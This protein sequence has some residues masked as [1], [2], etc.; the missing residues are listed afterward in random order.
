MSST[1][2]NMILL[3]CVNDCIIFSPSMESI[4]HLVKPENFKLTDEGNVNKFLGIEITK[5]DSFELL[6]PFLIDRLLA[7]LGFCNNSFETNPNSSL[8]STPVAE[9]LLH[10]DLA[11]KPRKYKWKYRMAVGMLSYLQNSTR[12]EIAMVVHQTAQFSNEPML[13]HVKSIMCLGRD[14][15]NTCKCGAI[16]KSDWSK[17]LECYMLCRCRLCRGMVPSRCFER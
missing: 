8:T 14:L 1:F 2:N 17:G 15:L 9:G 5:I 12:L 3:T 16:Y 11:G 4:N 6:Q 7:F 13:S 10:R